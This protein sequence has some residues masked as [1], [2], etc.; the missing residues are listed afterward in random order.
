L[1]EEHRQLLLDS[2]GNANA[3]IAKPQATKAMWDVVQGMHPKTLSACAL[4]D[5]GSLAHGPIVYRDMLENIME[6]GTST[7]P[8]HLKVKAWHVQNKRDGVPVPFTLDRL[9][10]VLMPRQALLRKLDPEGDLSVPRLKTLLEPYQREYHDLIVRDRVPGDMDVKA[11]LNIYKNFHILCRQP[12]WGDVP[13][14]CDC[15]VCFGNCVCAHTLLFTS[16]FTPEVC[17]P[18]AWVAATIS[19]RKKSRSLKGTAGRKRFRILEERMDDE[20]RIDSKV[21]H[22]AGTAAAFAM[23]APV[24]PSDSSDD[25]F[26]VCPSHPSVRVVHAG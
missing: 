16:L 8:L 19:Q 9:K 25:D 23:P 4:L 5:Y 6:C 26:Q 20:K 7:T 12:S 2:A 14:S 24:D 10:T 18:S 1:G 22:L 15:E 13:L 3:F 21:M 11:A 17:V